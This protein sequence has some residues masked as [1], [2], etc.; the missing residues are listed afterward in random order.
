MKSPGTSLAC[1]A[2]AAKR[3]DIPELQGTVTIGKTVLGKPPT[4]GQCTDNRLKHSPSLFIN[5]AY[6]LSLQL[7]PEGQA[8]GFPHME[9]IK[10]YTQRT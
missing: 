5:K 7:Q 10:R 6:V 4:P 9:G 3:T 1:L 2:L 8:S